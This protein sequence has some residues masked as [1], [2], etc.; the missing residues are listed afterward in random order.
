MILILAG[1]GH[2]CL[3]TAWALVAKKVEWIKEEIDDDA[4]ED[5]AAGM[6]IK[7]R[8]KTCSEKRGALRNVKS[9]KKSTSVKKYIT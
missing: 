8:H 1:P 5:S 3:P 4:Q 7:I 9:P 6:M 2:V